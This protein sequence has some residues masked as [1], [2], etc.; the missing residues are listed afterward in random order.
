MKELIIIDGYNLIFQHP[1][2]SNI[3][4]AELEGARERLSQLLDNFFGLVECDGV[5][6]FDATKNPNRKISITNKMG[7]DIVFTSKGQT[8]DTFIER[9]ARLQSKDRNVLVV[10][11]DYLQQ[12]TVFGGNVRRMSSREFIEELGWM[13][14][15]IGKYFKIHH[16]DGRKSIEYRLPQEIIDKLKKK[17]FF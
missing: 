10:T 8:A 6:V 4:K 12:K 11:S 1:E 3:A 2:L 17:F 16:P 14:K 15:E 9:E 5:L 7:Y 13:D